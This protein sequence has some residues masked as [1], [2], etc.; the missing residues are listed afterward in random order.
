MKN[1]VIN[2]DESEVREVWPIPVIDIGCWTFTMEAC[3]LTGELEKAVRSVFKTFPEVIQHALTFTP[4]CGGWA[5]RARFWQT[6]L[7]LA[8]P[9]KQYHA[10]MREFLA[11]YVKV[12]RKRQGGLDQYNL[13]SEQNFM[14]EVDQFLCECYRKGAAGDSTP[15]VEDF[16]TE[17][18]HLNE[19]ANLSLEQ[20]FD[21]PGIK[22]IYHLG[23][24]AYEQG[25]KLRSAL[26]KRRLPG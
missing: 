19:K 9:P 21:L 4:T 20:D 25:V 22:R 7:N 24:G 12:V 8:L 13:L 5:D 14:R 17:L 23:C 1:Q 11:H 3:L 26:Q 2:L 16:E 6:V 15:F 10:A 18:K